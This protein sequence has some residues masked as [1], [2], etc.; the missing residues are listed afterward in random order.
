[1]VVAQLGKVEDILPIIQVI[2]I[3]IGNIGMCI[4]IYIL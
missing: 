3:Y 2:Y 1:M 4:F